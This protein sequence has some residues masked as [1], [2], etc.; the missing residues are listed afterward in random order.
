[1]T[2][3]R[4]SD[5]E[6]LAVLVPSAARRW[7]GILTMASLGGLLIWVA[8]VAQPTLF[9]QV[10]FLAGGLAAVLGAV[11]MHRATSDRIL[12]TRE[13]LVTGAGEFVASV[14][15]VRQV[16]RGAFAFKPSNGFLIRLKEPDGDGAW[17]PG[18]WWRRGTFV[19][20]G[21]VVPGGQSRA[22]AEVLTALILDMLPED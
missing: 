22:M 16:E 9:W 19:G 4:S 11:R 10:A 17:R 7:I 12:L 1:M 18:L 14:A 15:N 6:I 2:S 8:A 13:V 3:Q 21:G 20:I 5:D